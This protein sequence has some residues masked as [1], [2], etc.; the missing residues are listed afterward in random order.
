[1]KKLLIFLGALLLLILVGCSSTDNGAG[2]SVSDRVYSDD[3]MASDG[4]AND[5][6]K[7]DQGDSVNNETGESSDQ[8]QEEASKALPFEL[9]DGIAKDNGPLQVING[10]LSNADGDPIQLKGLSSHGLQWFGSFITETSISRFKNEWGIDVLR[11]AMYTTE[12][13]YISDYKNYSLMGMTKSIDLATK[14]GIYVIVDWHVHRDQDPMAH[15][16][17]AKEFFSLIAETYANYDNIIY[18]ICNEPN[19]PITWEDNI[20]PYAEVIIPLIRSYDEDAVCIVGT[21]SYSQEVDKAADNPL[22]FDNVLY[23][24]HF[25]AG[26]HGQE[27]RDVAQYAL[28][29]G[30][31]I[32]VTEWGTSRNTGS[33]GVF[34]EESDEWLAFLDEHM[35]SWCNWSISD[36]AESSAIFLPN[37]N[38]DGEWP[39]DRISESGHYVRS[40]LLED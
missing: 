38:P 3:N 22:D 21:P 2:D 7:S 33:G 1:M 39:E 15:I 24:L 20:K 9:G 5:V 31:G 19:G 34:T 28:D 12:E 30:I 13:G 27:L 25:Y 17:E 8:T 35:I 6:A 11:A 18:E 10:Q 23:T 40:K 4:S 14:N 32:F 29:Q 37:I 16:E 26:S 36:K